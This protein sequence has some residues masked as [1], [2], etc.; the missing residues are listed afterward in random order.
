MHA[1]ARSSGW[2]PA[3]AAMSRPAPDHA[4]GLPPAWPLPA[5]WWPRTASTGARRQRGHDAADVADEAE[6]EHAV[7]LVEHEVPHQVELQVPGGQQV[8]DR[9]GRADDDVDTAAHP[10]HLRAVADAAEDGGQAE[11]LAIAEAS[12]G[13][14]DLQRQLAGRRQD[15]RA[16]WSAA[17]AGAAW[18]ARCCSSGRPNAAVLPVP[19]WA[20]PSRSRPASSAGMAPDWMGVGV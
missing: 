14:L 17:A 6:V 20:T 11:A 10:L 4:G 13:F 12:A 7:G 18:S 3:P 1:A 8:A 2:S 9:P 16:S 19:V 5:A 15:Q